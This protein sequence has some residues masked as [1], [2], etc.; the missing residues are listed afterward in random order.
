MANYYF[1]SAV[2]ADRP[3]IVAAVTEELFRLGCNLEDSA[4]MRL[5][6]EFGIFLIFTTSKKLSVSGHGSL[7]RIGKKWKLFVSLK[8]ISPS[9]ARF[10]PAKN[11]FIV[12]VHGQDRPGI[13][14]AV[15]RC[16]TDERF[17]I[18]DLSTHRTTQGPRPGYIL[19]IEGELLR[20]GS[21][22][23]LQRRLLVLGTKL[24]TKITVQ[25]VA[26]SA[27]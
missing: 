7:Q 20:S 1:M 6:S 17:N 14:S 24:R 25:P 13:V 5:G 19:F 22:E 12:A 10:Q 18:T 21:P 26:P 4:M 16:L 2:G 11:S 8:D 23:S 15:T 27:L 3:G 9:E